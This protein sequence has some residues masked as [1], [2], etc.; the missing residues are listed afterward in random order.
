LSSN[1]RPEHAR[2]T[3]LPKGARIV[4]QTRHAFATRLAHDAEARAHARGYDEGVQEAL[5]GAAGALER[6][7]VALDEARARA[8]DELAHDAVQ[9]GVEIAREL[10]RHEIDQGHYDL[11]RIVRET[12]HTS[13][14]G[15][16]ACVVHLNP[17]DATRLASA[18]F[19][20]G[21]QI[22][23]DPEVARGDVQVTTSRGLLVRDVEQALEAISERLR[24]D[25]A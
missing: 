5:R 16:A 8:R 10:L 6:A 11:E 1:P 24:Q 2:L 9:L 19:R 14:V 7:S 20:T 13:G 3:S 12:L 22:E 4:N 25:I 18:T 17:L 23:A 15:R 21:T